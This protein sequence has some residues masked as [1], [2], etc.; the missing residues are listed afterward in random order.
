MIYSMFSNV[1]LISFFVKSFINMYFS[2]Y[3]FIAKNEGSKEIGKCQSQ[4]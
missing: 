2:H 4:F 1:N 3:A